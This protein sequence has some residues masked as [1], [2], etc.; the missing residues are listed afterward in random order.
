MKILLDLQT[1]Q[2]DSRNRGIGRYA[3]GL[4]RA[5]LQRDTKIV[6]HL[7]FNLSMPVDG[8]PAFDL[9]RERIHYFDSPAPTRGI[10][11]ANIG[12]RNASEVIRDAFVG[13]QHFD[14]IHIVSPFDG[15]GDETVVGWSDLCKA[16]VST[17][18]YDLIPFQERNLYYT[19]PSASAWYQARLAGVRKAGV[20]LTLSEFIKHLVM[21][22]LNIPA[23]RVF[24][25]GADVDPIFLPMKFSH[26][27]SRNFLSR[28]GITQ[29]FIMH[30]GIIEQ[31]KNIGRLTTAFSMLDPQVRQGHQ[32]VLVGSTTDAQKKKII[33]LGDRLGI[34]PGKIVFPGFVPDPDLARLYNLAKVTV[35]PSISEGFGLSLLEA[36]RCHCPVLG[37][38]VTSIPEVIGTPE[39]LFDP[40]DARDMERKLS[41]ILVDSSFRRF[42]VEH[43][44][45]QQAKFSW[46]RA[47]AVAEQ[48]FQSAIERHRSRPQLV[49]KQK[50]CLIARP[51]QLSEPE[52]AV[53]SE[54]F[55]S[56][57]K[58][59]DITLVDY[60]ALTTKA[61]EYTYDN[62]AILVI[63]IR[64]TCEIL[65]LLAR[66]PAVVVQLASSLPDELLLTLEE[67]YQVMGWAAVKYHDIQSRTFSPESILHHPN[68]LGLV[69]KVSDPK[70]DPRWEMSRLGFGQ[71]WTK[72]S[73]L[74]AGIQSLWQASTLS[75]VVDAIPQLGKLARTLHLRGNDRRALANILATN[76]PSRSKRYLFV[77]ITE[78]TKFDGRS[79]I[80]R[81]VRNILREIIDHNNTPLRVE[82]VYRDDSVYRYARG[83]TSRFL[84]RSVKL[85]EAIV[86]FQPS[87]IFLGL[88]L[89]LSV[90]KEAIAT[91]RKHQLRGMRV[92]YVVYD[93]LPL[94]RPEWFVD[95]M[96]SM[97]SRWLSAISGISDRLI[98][99]SQ[100]VAATL[101]QEL[102][103]R[104]LAVNRSLEIV[105]F[106]LGS[107]LEKDIEA[108]PNKLHPLLDSL[109]GCS[110][111]FV[112]TSVA[113]IEPRKGHRQILDAFD[114]LWASGQD[115]ALSLVGNRG[116]LTALTVRRIQTHPE[117]NRRLFWFEGVSDA[118]LREIYSRSA[119]VVLASEGEGFGLPLVEAAR[120]TKPIIARDLPVFREVA[121]EGA[122][123]FSGLSG[124]DLAQAIVDWI[125][126]HL[127][128]RVPRSTS[129]NLRSWNEAAMQ[130]LELVDRAG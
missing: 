57:L 14:L 38:N 37:S 10:D 109:A 73:H 82:P 95:G 22:L 15:F 27:D 120:H 122:F 123:Y 7:L 18:V 1:L 16:I 77:D 90:T 129:I 13:S 70:V 118:T 96:S 92:C 65:N 12:R 34:G 83:F 21:D 86:D 110:A 113:T 87:D 6:W 5:L 69:R 31:R 107:D 2:S 108:Q 81:V 124:A 119:A 4:T 115:V 32:L 64:D 19:T 42:A 44:M 26:D 102:R 98:C 68:C 29:K 117:L 35:M 89:D 85:T 112:F 20:I 50:T 106:V 46:E 54:L 9:P 114:I 74:W 105:S 24:N 52:N 58:S 130:L 25:I 45:V 97:F 56:L 47:A 53:F 128:G 55:Q 71:E 94:L 67:T 116:W 36:M 127:S 111:R 51:P 126:L 11:N 125:D 40:L 101:I 76:H 30:T 62:N 49:M 80:Q 88:D 43:V 17:T 121:A 39:L 93:V 63:V 72:A 84:G 99:I 28:Y 3:A 33:D 79:G 23:D 60:C 48:A 103:S 41:Q 61:K 104:G 8:L 59:T 91:L 100:S 66:G 75:I 78:L